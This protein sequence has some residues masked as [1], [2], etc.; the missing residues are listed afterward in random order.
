MYMFK[1]M[2]DISTYNFIPVDSINNKLFK[3]NVMEQVSL[4]SQFD[5]MQYTSLNLILNLGLI[6]YSCIASLMIVLIVKLL[7]LLTLKQRL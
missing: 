6:F 7:T 4:S 2:I 3:Q 1:V 5:T